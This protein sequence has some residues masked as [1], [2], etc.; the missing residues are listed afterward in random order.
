MIAVAFL[1]TA[2]CLFYFV[3]IHLTWIFYAV[4]REAGSCFAFEAWCTERTFY[5]IA[6]RWVPCKLVQMLSLSM[7]FANKRIYIHTRQVMQTSLSTLLLTRVWRLIYLWLTWLMCLRKL[8]GSLSASLRC[9]QNMTL[10]WPASVPRVYVRLF[11]NLS[12]S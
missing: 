2:R 11:L 1:H 12:V 6:T 8:S 3:F 9:R 4:E 10:C 7:Q 5:W